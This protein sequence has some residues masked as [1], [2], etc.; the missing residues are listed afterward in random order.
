MG[1]SS[2]EPSFTVFRIVRRAGATIR[3]TVAPVDHGAA[4]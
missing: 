3:G 4:A 1:V 2:S